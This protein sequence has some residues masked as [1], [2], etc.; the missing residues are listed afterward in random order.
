MKLLGYTLGIMFLFFAGLQ[1]NDPDPALW[2]SI[3]AYSA[4]LSF[5]AANRIFN[6][7]MLTLG[8]IAYLVT[9]VFFYPVTFE[10]FGEEMKAE[11]PNIEI[12]REFAGLMICVITTAGFLMAGLRTRKHKNKRK[13]T[14]S[15]R[16]VAH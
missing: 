16:S 11:R 13:T 7:P 8:L 9:S 12:A 14:R 1:Y 3:Y 2:I 6:V 4:I 10:G 15:K 5:M